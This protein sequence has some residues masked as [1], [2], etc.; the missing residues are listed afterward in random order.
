M[1]VAEPQSAMPK[2]KLRWFQFS[3]R[4]LL[5]ATTLFVVLCALFSWQVKR[6]EYQKECIRAIHNRGGYVH[7]DYQADKDG[8]KPYA[9]SPVPKYLL[10]WLGE[11]FFHRVVG[12]QIWVLL[13]CDWKVDREESAFEE[14]CLVPGTTVPDDCERFGPHGTRKIIWPRNMRLSAVDW[15]RAALRQHKFGCD[16]VSIHVEYCRNALKLD[17]HNIEANLLLGE[18]SWEGADPRL[19]QAYLETV[20]VCAKPESLEYAQAR[21][22]LAREPWTFA[23][24]CARVGPDG[25][26][27]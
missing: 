18:A 26:L 14:G 13:P 3:L 15:A 2:S 4:S 10:D 7:Y 17:P 5:V 22:R 16:R 6:A 9:S 11:D 8:V 1:S 25:V 21:K 19:C 24:L 20:L 27:R 12:V 23:E